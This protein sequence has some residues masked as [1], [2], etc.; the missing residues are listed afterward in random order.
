LHVGL[1]SKVLENMPK[2][3]RGGDDLAR[4]LHKNRKTCNGGRTDSLASGCLH[5]DPNEDVWTE[6]NDVVKSNLSK[7]V[8]SLSL[9]NGDT[10]LFACTGV[11]VDR[12]GRLT[13]F[14]TSASLV[15]LLVRALNDTNKNHGDLELEVYHEGN[16]VCQGYLTDF[17][18]DHNL[19]IVEIWTDFDVHVGLLQH[20]V[21]FLPHCKVIAIG[22]EI[23]GK[24]MAR[25]VQLMDDLSVS[26]DSEDLDCKIKEAWEGAPLFSFDGNFVG[27]NLFLAMGRAFFLPWGTIQKHWASLQNKTGLPESNSLKVYR[28]G[29]SSTAEKSNSHPEV[30][31]DI[32][33]PEQ[34]HIDSMGYP[35]FPTHMFADGM[36][37]VNTFEETFGDLRG[38]GVWSKLSKKSCSNID[39]SV[40]ALASFSGER[41]FFACTGFFVE[42]NGS[43]VILTSASLVRSSGDEN[44]IVDNLRIEVLLPNKQRV[45]GML[46]HC[47]LHYNVALVSVGYR[48][49]RPAHGQ[50]D[51]WGKSSKV[52]AVG[53]CFKSGALMAASGTV[54]PWTGTLDC[55]F[56]ERSSC[57]ITK[58]GIG[59]P[60]VTLDGDC[61]GMNFYDT[62]IGTPFL[63]WEVIVDIVASFEEKR[64]PVPM[65]Y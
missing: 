42:W 3:K 15:E 55:D 58:A 53:R 21:E 45:E 20:A 8:A 19:A 48:A 30:N 1:T 18:L 29:T 49:L 50:L 32:L 25:R 44:K 4:S 22:R 65:P 47:N 13:K 43:T 23:T 63:S 12:Q 57:K 56:L 11:A 46:Q 16:E 34:I 28:F 35:K 60:V 10:V 51:W 52:V 26:E 37:L 2:T 61:I 5:G 7:S 64:W 39:R 38:E 24:L 14:L 27:M 59:G 17:D 41:R 36:I 54:T 40:V 6:L 33:D 62:R 31:N 9:R